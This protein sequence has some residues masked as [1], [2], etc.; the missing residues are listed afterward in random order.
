MRSLEGG[1]SPEK[2]APNLCA[3]HIVAEGV[4]PDDV[5]NTSEDIADGGDPFAALWEAGKVVLAEESEGRREGV[6]PADK[7]SP[8]DLAVMSRRRMMGLTAAAAV[9]G[10]LGLSAQRA[11]AQEGRALNY[12]Y[13]V[14]QFFKPENNAKLADISEK[15]SK[16]TPRQIIAALREIPSV[17]SASALT[18]DDLPPVLGPHKIPTREQP[19]ASN[20]PVLWVSAGERTYPD[21]RKAPAFVDA[22]PVVGRFGSDTVLTPAGNLEGTRMITPENLGLIRRGIS[23]LVARLAPRAGASRSASFGKDR[24][25]T[26]PIPNLRPLS[27]FGFRHRTAEEFRVPRDIG[28]VNATNDQWDREMQRRATVVPEV[29]AGVAINLATH[30]A[31][32]NWLLDQ[33]FP[34][35]DKARPEHMRVMAER[36]KNMSLIPFPNLG[37]EGLRFDVQPGASVLSISE[38]TRV[39]TLAGMAGGYVNIHDSEPPHN[40]KIHC[41]LIDNVSAFAEHVTS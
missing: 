19:D 18:Q 5:Q 36:L 9:V 22:I 26:G 28:S 40:P 23:V 8:E 30:D 16:G 37:T 39:S 35:K 33:P 29:K 12:W 32:R 11:E 25:H 4:S 10:G 1:H 31:L 6:P 38:N 24:I 27:V 41:L 15:L 3:G 7:M 34:G 17:G 2:S 20:Y 21:G 14:R 13:K